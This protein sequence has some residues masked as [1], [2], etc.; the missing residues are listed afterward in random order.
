MIMIGISLSSIFKWRTEYILP[1]LQ[2][3][4]LILKIVIKYS[5]G[6]FEQLYQMPGAGFL[7]FQNKH[8]STC[9]L[10]IGIKCLQIA[11]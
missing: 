4:Y 1:I 3:N 6:L 10:K 9:Y 5:T 2:D 8:T 7:D 11:G